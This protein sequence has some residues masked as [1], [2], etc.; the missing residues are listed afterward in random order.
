MSAERKER[1]A[2][3]LLLDAFVYLPAGVAVTLAE[4]LPR[5]AEKGR[6]R[7][8]G[9][10]AT[11]R[12]VGQ[13]AV[14]MGRQMGKKRLEEVAS[15]LGSLAGAGRGGD[16]DRSYPGPSGPAPRERG[17]DGAGGSASG[18]SDAAGADIS[19]P[20]ST[21]V[22]A[23]RREQPS[24]GAISNGATTALGIPG[25]DTLSASQ[26]VQRLDGLQE[27]ELRAVRD[28]ELANRHRRTILNRVEQLLAQGQ[29]G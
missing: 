6:Q 22:R 23:K 2:V 9:Q 27:V 5:L 21:A 18:P 7:V 11:A 16:S 28:Y 12:V 13:F 10:V 24:P 14:Q 25:Y 20:G 29:G 8:D 3:D 15:R 4:E 26:V 1:S 17:E 19:E